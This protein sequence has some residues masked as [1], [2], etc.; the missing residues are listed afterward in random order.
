MYTNNTL[1]NHE[2]DQILLNYSII[3][4]TGKEKLREI[5]EKIMEIWEITHNTQKEKQYGINS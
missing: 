5:S 1:K 4:E 3:N 2:V